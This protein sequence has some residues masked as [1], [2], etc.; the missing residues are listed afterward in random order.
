MENLIK[1]YQL[2]KRMAIAPNLFIAQL[3]GKDVTVKTN[4]GLAFTGK[5][6]SYLEASCLRWMET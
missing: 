1:F 6:Y 2:H 4:A 5:M 3:Y